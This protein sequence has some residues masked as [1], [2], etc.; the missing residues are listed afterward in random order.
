M[1]PN[2]LKIKVEEAGHEP[3]FFN[4]RTMSFFGDTM[5]NYGVRDAENCWE[6]YRKEPVKYDLSGSAYFNK[7]TFRRIYPDQKGGEK[8]E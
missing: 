8:H 3:F 2:E 7:Q 1:T 4:Y 5:G 6:L